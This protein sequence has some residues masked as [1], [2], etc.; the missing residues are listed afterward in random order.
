MKRIFR[1]PIFWCIIAILAASFIVLFPLL[2]RGFFI[3]DDG[4]WMVIRLSAFFQSFREGQF[5]VRFLG[6]LNNGFGYPVANFL[7]PGFLYL[8]SFIHIFNISFPDTIKIIFAG[9]VILSAFFIFGWLR[10]KFSG[11]ASLLGTI[12]FI[13]SP[14]LLFDIYKRGSVGEVLAL[15]PAAASFYAVESGKYWLLPWA[16]GLLVISHNSLALMLLTV[17]A[18]YVL[19]KGLWKLLIP[20]AIGLGLAT[21]FWFPA[22]H[23]LKYVIFDRIAVSNPFDYFVS[24]NMIMLLGFAGVAAAIIL[25][26]ATGRKLARERIFFLTFFTLSIILSTGFGAPVWKISRFAELFQ[27]PF[28]FL[29]IALF[30]GSW[31]VAETLDLFE[32]HLRILAVLFAVF[33]LVAI[34]PVFK[35]LVFVERP[36]S[37]YTTNEGTTTVSDEY[38]PNWV[39]IKPSE[40]VFQ[41]MIIYRGNGTLSMIRDGTQHLEVRAKLSEPSLMQI[42]FIYYPGWGVTVDNE[43]VPIDYHNSEG[44]IRF[45][46]PKGDHL[47]TADFRETISRFLADLISLIFAGLALIYSVSV[48]KRKKTK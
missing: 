47:I 2:Q 4:E 35:N 26:L 40:H 20:I 7:Y 41:R 11:R 15:L 31:L 1:N 32:K 36:E 6:R 37:F 18:A 21:F 10:T 45:E 29:A 16:V 23:E 39:T 14:Y 38:L 17:L 24:G 25:L 43:R 28:R 48:L 12:N 8:G 3:S 30:A 46:V 5:P 9:S 44:L 34:P 19:I 27:F 22:Q 42:N 13:L 33:W